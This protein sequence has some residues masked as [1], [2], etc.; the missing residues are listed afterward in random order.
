MTVNS[1]VVVLLRFFPVIHRRASILP[2][3]N[4]KEPKLSSWLPEHHTTDYP[5]KATDNR[6]TG[7]FPTDCTHL[8]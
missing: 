6:T 1:N 5:N 2:N 7:T 3:K 4:V 8:V